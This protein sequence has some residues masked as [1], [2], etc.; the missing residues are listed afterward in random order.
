MR[1]SEI[2]RR[3]APSVVAAERRRTRWLA[4]AVAAAIALNLLLLALAHLP[5]SKRL[6]GD[7]QYYFDVASTR[8]RGE[9]RVDDPFWPPLYPRVL[10]AIFLVFG[11][12]VLAVQLLQVSLWLVACFIWYGIARH[13]WSRGPA[14]VVVLLLLLVCADLAPFAHYLWPEILH[15]ALLGSAIALLMR[16]DRPPAA[17]LLAGI[18]AGLAVL[19]KLLTVLWLPLAAAVAATR[20]SGP[21]ARRLLCVV[22]LVSGFAV[23]VAPVAVRN[24]RAGRPLLAS[25][26]VFNIWLGLNDPPLAAGTPEIG[27]REAR[28]YRSSG[29]SPAER[30]AVYRERILAKVRADGLAATV[31]NQLAK[32]YARLLDH[33]T[34][35]VEQLPGGDRGAY[36]FDSPAL[37]ALLHGYADVTHALLLVA[38]AFGVALLRWRPFAWPQL[39]ASFLLYNLAMFTLLHVNPRFLVQMVPFLAFFGGAAVAGVAGDGD[40]AEAFASPTGN[41]LLAGGALA[42]VLLYLAF[43]SVIGM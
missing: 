13:V 7:E 5:A 38:A 40:G 31:R 32:Q 14:P 19:T 8:A 17:D 10:T 39:F 34:F 30:N 11:T 4:A 35:L 41:R 6:E 9:V 36:R 25:S 1:P 15:V 24:A 2:V 16:A 3:R 33:R 29:D 21:R 27:A 20:V 37:R 22:L 12:R 18:A 42:I 43:G 26:A 23:P 28:R